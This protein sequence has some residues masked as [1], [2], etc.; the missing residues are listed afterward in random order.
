M[1]SLKNILLL[2]CLT[3]N[4]NGHAQIDLPS[5]KSNF[6]WDVNNNLSKNVYEVID[7]NMSIKYFDKYGMTK[8]VELKI[9]DW[10][11]EEIS[12][13]R[14]D[15]AFGLNYYTIDLEGISS[16]WKLD[17]LYLCEIH[18]EKQR[19]Y[20]WPMKLVKN[21]DQNFLQVNIIVNPIRLECGVA[22]GNQVEFYSEIGNGK[23]PYVLQ[24]YVMNNNKSEFLYQP[25]EEIVQHNN[26]TSIIQVEQQPDYY[27]MLF[28]K[29]ACGN[30]Q[31]KMVHL[32]CEEGKKII[33]SL[34]VEPIQLI[35][36]DQKSNK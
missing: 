31:Q 4:F 32:I 9:Y 27:V 1:R 2:I 3:V 10:K 14:L 19:K 12:R 30:I 11:Q 26:E 33:N 16:G 6:Y 7:L 23:A 29:D 15:K 17:Q 35:P 20:E 28:V 13:L 34:F 24:W 5:D 8:D 22:S 25:K 21:T 36:A 18:D